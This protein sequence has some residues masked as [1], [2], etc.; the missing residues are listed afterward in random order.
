MKSLFTRFFSYIR[1]N[2][3]KL[4]S[5]RATPTQIA[6]GFAIGV[7]IGILPTFGLGALVIM[8]IAA[9]WKFNI[10]AALLGTLSGNPLL[11]PLW[12]TLSCAIAQL[13]PSEI[14]IPDESFFNVMA[15]YGQ[16]GLR[17][18]LGNLLISIVFA[19]VGYFIVVFFVTKYQKRK[20]HSH[21]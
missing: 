11:A 14:K 7:F 20:A 12:I 21:P 1:Q 18:L 13:N 6:T 2:I 4:L 16:L 8:G 9:I 19:V 15:H 3:K 17:F 10:P 5:L